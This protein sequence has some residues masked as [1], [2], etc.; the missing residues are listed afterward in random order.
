MTL[1]GPAADEFTLPRH[2]LLRIIF[3]TSTAL[4]IGFSLGVVT[5]QIAAFHQPKCIEGKS[6]IAPSPFTG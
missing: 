3:W 2:P 6:E 4:F 1:S 5:S